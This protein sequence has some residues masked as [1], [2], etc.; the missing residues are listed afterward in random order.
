[1]HSTAN[2]QNRERSIEDCKLKSKFSLNTRNL[3]GVDGE[4]VKKASVS[5]YVFF[6]QLQLSFLPVVNCEC[7]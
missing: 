5:F 2:G 7:K 3:L 4:R 1:M 6:Q